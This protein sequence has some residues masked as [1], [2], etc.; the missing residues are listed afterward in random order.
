MSGGDDEEDAGRDW[1]DMNTRVL[2]WIA[3]SSVCHAD[4]SHAQTDWRVAVSPASLKDEAISVCLSDLI[5][6]GRENGLILKTVTDERTPSANA[7]VVGDASRNR[8][9]A[10]L[11]RRGALELV[12]VEHP[13]GYE[14]VPVA[15]GNR[16]IVV[17]AG[18]SLIGDV[19]GLYWI[20]DRIRV[21]KRVPTDQVKHQPDLETRYTR[22]PVRSRADI[23][24]A[25]R[26]RLNLVFGETPLRLVPWD[27]EPERTENRKAR[28]QA[29]ELAEYAHA[30]HMKFMPFGTEFT[31]H[32]SLLA[33]FGATLSPSDPRLWDAVR[34]KFRR[35]LQAM[36]E[37]DGVATFTGEEQNYWG[38]YQT[39]DVM[40]DG[41]GCDWSLAKRYR[42]FVKAVWDVVVGEFDKDLLHRTWITNA[43]EQQSQPEVYRSVFTDDVPTRNLYLI[44][45]FTQND[46]WW[47]QPYNPTLNQTPHNMMVVC[48]TMDYHGGANVFPTYPGTYFQAGLTSMLRAG[49]S[50]LKGASLDMPAKEGW[51]TRSLTAYTV[52]R[53]TW[54]HQDKPRDIAADYCAIYFGRSLAEAM[55]D[56]CLLSPSAYKYGLYI[57][58]VAY[59]AFSSL[60]H[61]RVGNFVA[62]GYPSIDGGKEHL[63]F[64]REIYLRCKPWIPET[65]T[66]LDHGLDVAKTMERKYAAV[67]TRVPDKGFAAKVADSLKLTR[68]LIQANHFY[69]KTFLAYFQ[70]SEDPTDEN[71]RALGRL[72]EELT[73]T[74]KAFVDAPGFD[75][76]LFGVDE[77]IKNVRQTLEDPEGARKALARAP[78]RDQIERTVAQ[79]QSRYREVLRTHGDKATKI[80]YWEGRVDGRDILSVRGD[81]LETE[82]LRWDPIY[83]QN[84]T[85][86]TPLPQKA[87][88]V[89]VEDIE[90]EPMHPFILEQP[91]AE[92]DYTAKIYLYDV[93]GGAHWVK[94]NLYFIN[95][96]P[97]ALGL[98]LPWK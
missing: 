47:Y 86:S 61:I 34:A 91:S 92:N 22:I 58:P 72:F 21:L 53:L 44:P 56:I 3:L 1:P 82:H 36:P 70:Y 2:G 32:P 30:L 71:L 93:P 25:L 84:H 29:R 88:T 78:S 28:A 98:R 40:H 5:E 17:V 43:H 77:L 96:G 67:K 74:R 18:G 51:D 15:D 42:A 11:R 10:D 85:F 7:I 24:R 79:Q 55:A 16:T 97:E 50:N 64:L 81:H 6:T 59:G 80:L 4:I 45:S 83:F 52:S 13:Q 75:Y 12:G 14:I 41:E 57:E 73:T 37:L 69:T 90:S 62:E 95:E 63:E 26:Y 27:A 39:F 76:H 89:I 48:E 35:L 87:G 8:I 31:Y 38:N 66:Y 49:K 20:W 23:R 94:F 60:P 46:R 33:E 9:T 65:L 19:Y 54:D 68:L